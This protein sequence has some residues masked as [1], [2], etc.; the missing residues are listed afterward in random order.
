MTCGV[1]RQRFKD[2]AEKFVDTTF[3]DFTESYTI[4]SLTRTPDGQGGYTVSWS[5]F[6]TITGFVKPAPRG[7]GQLDSYLKSLT[8][9]I[10]MFEYVAGITPEMRINYDSKVYNIRSIDSVMDQDIWITLVGEEQVA[11]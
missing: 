10:F 4:E 3:N 5:T 6:A 8:N 11:T 1:T 9:K 7:E 2:L